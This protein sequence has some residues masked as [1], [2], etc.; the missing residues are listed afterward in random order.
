[1][2]TADGLRPAVG[3]LLLALLAGMPPER[4]PGQELPDSSDAQEG[5]LFLLLPVGAQGVGLGR[6]MTALHSEEAAFWN[7]AGLAGQSE[8][9]AMVYTGDQ[10]AGPALAVNVLLPWARVGTFGLSYYLLDIGD[11]K[12]TDPFNNVSGSITVRNHLGIASFGTSL[13]GG[14]QA[15]INMKLVQ[16]RIG[17]QGQCENLA[18][19]GSAYA[20]DVGVQAEPFGG[21][22]LRFGWMLAHAGTE[23]QIVNQ[24]RS[25][26][27]P[28]RLRF[29]VA[30]EVLHRFVDDGM[31]DL[32]LAVETEERPRDPGSPSVHV[33]LSFSAAG[34]VDLRAGYVAGQLD[35]IDGATVGLGFRFDRFDLNL[36][37]YLTRS[38]VTQESQ[39]VH[40]SLGVSF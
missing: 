21:L 13:P 2:A 27:L 26:P 4:A 10:L 6:A 23:F 12:I 40:V 38:M 16:F 11:Q 8:R 39:P 32:W 35:Q 24:E 20:V 7:P 1:M 31:M 29:A 36:A 15:G 34:V 22:P 14:F 25:D 5:A 28:T 19:T 3:V 37:K 30:Y 17:C 33:G 18:T 9:R